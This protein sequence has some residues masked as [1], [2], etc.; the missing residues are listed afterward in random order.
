MKLF[1]DVSELLNLNKV[2]NQQESTFD[3][4]I[5][6]HGSVKMLGGSDGLFRPQ[7]VS[8]K[9]NYVI[10]KS[11]FKMNKNYFIVKLIREFLCN[12]VCI[13][14]IEL[15]SINFPTIELIHKIDIFFEIQSNDGSKQ[16][17]PLEKELEIS[18]KINH[19]ETPQVIFVGKITNKDK[20]LNVAKRLKLIDLSL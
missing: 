9:I 17:F 2:E 3:T 19:L 14:K 7:P 5:K 15:T 6:V 1:D 8:E 20:N 11:H 13:Y 12:P 18:S 10:N 4:M 16:R